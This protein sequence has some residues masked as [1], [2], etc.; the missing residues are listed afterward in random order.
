MLSSGTLG[1]EN[2]W[3]ARLRALGPGARLVLD[4]EA[5]TVRVETPAVEFV[6]A[7]RTKAD[8]K[9][10]L[11]NVLQDV[12]ARLSFD[13]TH[14]VLPLSGGVDSRAILLM[15]PPD[16]RV[17]CV[18]W[19]LKESLNDPLNDAYLAKALAEKFGTGHVYYETDLSDEPV[20]SIV[21]RFLAAGEGRVDHL[22]GY[23]D[24]CR[25]WKR[26][27][28][29]KVAGILRGDHGFG[30]HAAPTSF[31]VRRSNGLTLLSDFANGNGLEDT[32]FLAQQLPERLQRRP[33]ESLLQWR[34]RLQHEFRIP[35]V[36]AALNDIKCAYV[37]VMNPLL[38]HPVI[39][40]ARQLPDELRT[41]KRLFEDLVREKSPPI[42]FAER[43]A[44]ASLGNIQRTQQVV[45]MMRDELSSGDAQTLFPRQW[46]D[47]VIQTL[48]VVQDS[49]VRSSRASLRSSLK[50]YVPTGLRR[51]ARHVLARGAPSSLSGD[52]NQWAFRVLMI[53]R[54]VRMLNA[55][56][57]ALR[58]SRN[59]R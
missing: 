7:Q 37:E 15:L 46:L 52:A 20:E 50:R 4:R 18:T 36:L 6:P 47:R 59:S 42:P 27:Y 56:A 2:T 39:H 30:R 24:G 43:R 54:T 17:R 44:I 11:E 23:M 31:E 9:A 32:D 3:D 53:A 25:I 55:D 21:D 35:V 13:P 58:S 8:H 1:P 12:F 5:W 41:D 26:L 40:C 29:E 38:T 51:L 34:D 28:E 57:A 22:S 10:H 45:D 33:R 16:R 14:W 19:G 49:T 48:K